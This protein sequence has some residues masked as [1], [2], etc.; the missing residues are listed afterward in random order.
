MS[1]C[2]NPINRV[3]YIRYNQKGQAA[4]AAGDAEAAHM[5]YYRAAENV[6]WGNLGPEYESESLYN[7]GRMKRI[8]GRLDESAELLERTVQIDEKIYGPKS[9]YLFGSLSELARTYYEKNEYTKGIP[10]L[11]KIEPM[12]DDVMQK[13]NSQQKEFIEKLFRIYAEAL[14]ESRKDDGQSGFLAVNCFW[15]LKWAAIEPA[16]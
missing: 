1:A 8:V 13:S 10:I 5:A 3:T 6:R 4:E 11:A 15:A 12:L 9:P 2:A 14:E 16:T 7:L